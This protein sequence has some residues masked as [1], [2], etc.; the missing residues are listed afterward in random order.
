MFELITEYWFYIFL[1][2][3]AGAWS[4]LWLGRLNAARLE[5][6]GDKWRAEEQERIDEINKQIGGRDA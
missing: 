1:S 5:K 2:I 3:V 6:L 4:S